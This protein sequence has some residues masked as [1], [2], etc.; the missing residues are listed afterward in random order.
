[1]SGALTDPPWLLAPT[2]TGRPIRGTRWRAISAHCVRINAA[3]AL[4]FEPV[5]L[6]RHS[7]RLGEL[8]DRCLNELLS[9]VGDR[10]DQA[11]AT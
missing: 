7:Q 8:L 2:R 10:R 4:S 11:A 3:S 1:M 9:N 6:A 5:L